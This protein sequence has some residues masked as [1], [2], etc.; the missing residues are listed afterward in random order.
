M[1]VDSG[2]CGHDLVAGIGD[3]GNTSGRQPILIMTKASACVMAA[4]KVAV[5][6]YR[7]RWL[8]KC[9]TDPMED[10]SYRNSEFGSTGMAWDFMIMAFEDMGESAGSKV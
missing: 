7:V 10:R 9:F 1:F 3:N 2:E 5:T 4:D 8:L 6:W